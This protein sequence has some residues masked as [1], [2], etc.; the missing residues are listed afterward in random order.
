MAGGLIPRRPANGAV[1]PAPAP[2]AG[3]R[4]ARTNR[5]PMAANPDLL[6]WLRAAWAAYEFDVAALYRRDADHDWPLEATDAK[7]LARKLEAGGHFLPLPKEPAA[8]ANVLEVSIVK[9]LMERAEAD[10]GVDIR[11]GTE[12]GYPDLEVSGARFGD[13]FHAVDLKAARRKPLKR[14]PPRETQSRIT[15]Y[16]GNTYFAWP[17]LAWPGMFR[18]FAEYESHVD[19]LAIYTLDLEAME[20][21]TDIEVLVQ[22]PWRIAST[23]RSSTTREYIGAVTKLDRLR[24]GDGDFDTEEAF[25]A[26]WRAFEFRMPKALKAQLRKLIEAQKGGSGGS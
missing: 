23:E 16:T 8:L 1:D 24:E 4:P 19:V 20:R 12:R 10:P 14:S 26:Y 3:R 13:G 21:A 18:P 6:A 15:L 9:F 17:D 11:V 2:R 5:T 22:E 25:Y 7:E